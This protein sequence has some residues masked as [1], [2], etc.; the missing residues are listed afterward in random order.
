VTRPLYAMSFE[1][2][3]F[4]FKNGEPEWFPAQRIR[5]A[6]GTHVV[7]CPAYAW[8][9]CYDEPNVNG[10]TLMNHPS[11]PSLISG[12]SI[13]RPGADIR[14]WDTLASILASAPFAFIFG[15]HP[16]LIICRPICSRRWGSHDH[17]LF[18]AVMRF[19]KRYKWPPDRSSLGV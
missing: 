3:I 13:D 15:G 5:H 7:E 14:M 16:P 8:G 18:G 11:D 17:D 10:V 4:G 1:V 2:F 12:F 19:Y 9:L 6:F